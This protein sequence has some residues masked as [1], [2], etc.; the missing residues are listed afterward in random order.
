[1][2]GLYSINLHIMGK[3]NIPLLEKPG[4]TSYAT[5]LNPGLPNEIW[6]CILFLAVMVCFWFLI[7]LFFKTDLGIT[8]RATGNNA[9]MAGS[10]GVNVNA[11]KTMGIALANGF[12]A[13]SGSLVAQYQGF[14]DIG[15]GIGSIAGLAAS[16]S[17]NRL[18]N[19]SH[20]EKLR[21]HH[22][23]HRLSGL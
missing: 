17:A 10:T 14:A 20:T 7:S 12:V 16:L 6:F 13:L 9:T 22:R 19:S 18:S 23:F 15:M 1:M 2:T 5:K 21:G 3:S 11:M 4:I 8:M